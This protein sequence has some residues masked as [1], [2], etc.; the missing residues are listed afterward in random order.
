MPQRQPEPVQMNNSNNFMQ[1]QQTVPPQQPQFNPNPLIAP[2]QQ[3]QQM[4][5]DDIF[6]GGMGAGPSNISL[7]SQHNESSF[8]FDKTVLMPNPPANGAA[9]GGSLANDDMFKFF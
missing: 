6:G 3:Q 4:M 5:F 7:S 9:S 2:P 8:D 1:M